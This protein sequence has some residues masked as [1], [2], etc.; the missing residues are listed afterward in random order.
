MYKIA[1]H[2]MGTPEYTVMEALDLFHQI[3]LDG[4]EIVIQD[5]YKSGLPMICSEE[6]LKQVKCCAEKNDI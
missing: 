4:A 2:T 6:T 5:G 1:G 3:G